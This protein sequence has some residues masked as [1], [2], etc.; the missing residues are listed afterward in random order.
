[1]EHRGV[2][3]Q[4]VGRRGDLGQV[5]RL[6]ANALQVQVD[7]QQ[8]GQQ[9]Q[10]GGDRGLECEQ[11]QDLPLHLQVERVHHIVAPDHLVAEVQV[12]A[13]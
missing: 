11:V 7:V 8:G 5:H 3:G 2:L 6:V 12:A 13:D 1:V 4:A 9:S 10:V